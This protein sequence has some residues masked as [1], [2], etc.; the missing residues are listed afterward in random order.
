M[1]T[2][3]EFLVDKDE[4]LAALATVSVAISS[5]LTM[6][7]T[8]FYGLTKTSKVEVKMFSRNVGR[9]YSKF[10]GAMSDDRLLFAALDY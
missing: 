7:L 2:K 6:H 4:M 10:G 8:K 3:P 9:T 1:A 5:P